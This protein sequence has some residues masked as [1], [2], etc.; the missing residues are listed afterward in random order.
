MEFNLL[1]MKLCNKRILGL[2]LVTDNINIELRL[3]P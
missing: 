1:V 2:G 3:N